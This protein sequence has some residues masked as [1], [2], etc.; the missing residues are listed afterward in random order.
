MELSYVRLRVPI[1]RQLQ[2]EEA[3][4]RS[5]TGNW[6]LFN[7]GSDPTV[8]MGLL[9]SPDEVRASCPFPIVRRFTGGGTVVVDEGTLLCSLILDGAD[10]PCP[11]T[12]PEIM[13]WS[14]DLFRPAFLPHELVLEEQDY[15]LDGKKIGGNAQ[16]F[17]KGRLVHHTSFLWS[18]REERMDVLLMPKRQPAYRAQREHGAFCNRL[19]NYFPSKSI[20]F[21]ALLDAVKV[22]FDCKEA[23]SLA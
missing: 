22:H 14:L 16:S 5:G 6:C 19:S 8:V 11:S 7:E 23:G 20:F 17:S 15:V 9:G 10:L 12:P 3:L 18:W 1:L 2:I 13:R 4:F 21:K